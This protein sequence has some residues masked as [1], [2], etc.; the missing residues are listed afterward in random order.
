MNGA[1]MIPRRA[2]LA[3]PAAALA[4][5]PSPRLGI[6][7]QLGARETGARRALDAARQAGFQTTMVNFAWD[8]VDAAFLRALPAWLRSAGLDCRA[9]GA[10][11]NCVQPRAVLMNTRAEDFARALG[12]AAGLGCNRLVAWTGSHR[13]DLMQADSRNFT[14]ESEDALLRFLE[15]HLPHLE[16]ARLTLALE[17]YHTLTCPDAPSLQ[18]VLQRLPACVTAVMDPPNLTP[19][20]RF[21]DRDQE[22]RAMFDVLRGR[23][24]VVH[25]KDFRLAPGGQAYELPGPLAGEMNYSLYAELVR[26]L[27]PGVPAFAEHIGPDSYRAVRDQLLPLFG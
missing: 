27:P 10:Y 3:L 24:G 13:T 14:R 11:V 1:V 6:L 22:L 5:A 19:V 4:A 18:R 21:P 26:A 7:C 8:Q 9:L 2:F 23:I 17:T 12:Y 25:L 16:R 20:A 15:P